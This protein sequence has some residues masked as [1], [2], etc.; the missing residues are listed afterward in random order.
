MKQ[1]KENSVLSTDQQHDLALM[2][3]DQLKIIGEFQSEGLHVAMAQNEALERKVDEYEAQQTN[4]NE[5]KSSTEPGHLVELRNTSRESD[6]NEDHT[7]ERESRL[8]FSQKYSYVL[9]FQYICQ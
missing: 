2:C 3:L 4:G 1:V 6:I 8:Y 9:T 7:I 5:D